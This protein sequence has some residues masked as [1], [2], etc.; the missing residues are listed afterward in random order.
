MIRTKT[1]DG[2]ITRTSFDTKARP[3]RTHVGTNDNG[4]TAGESSGTNDMTLVAE[5]VYD[6]ATNRVTS[7]RQ[8]YGTGGSDYRTTEYLYDAEGRR[9]VT[10]PPS[11][12]ISVVLYDHQGRTTAQG[13]YRTGASVTASTDPTSTATDRLA[14]TETSYDQRGQVWQTTRHEVN[15]SNGTL[16]S[17]LLA[18]HWFDAAGREIKTDGE[19]LTKSVYDRLGRMTR[20]FVLAKDNDRAT[21]YAD[22]VD[23][24][25]DIVL[26][27]RQTLYDATDGTATMS[28]SIERNY[29]DYR[30]GET[31]GALDTNADGNLGVVTAADIKGRVSITSMWYDDLDRLID[32]ASLGT[33]GGTTYTRSSYSSAPSRSATVLVS[34]TSYYDDG[35]VMSRTDPRGKVTLQT[36]DTAGRVTSTVR[37]FVNGAPSSATGDDDQIIRQVYANGLRTKYWVDLYPADTDGTPDSEDQVTTY[38]YGTSKGTS[39][40][41]SKIATGNLLQKVQYPDSSGG[42]DVVT[43]AYD[44]G[45]ALMWKKDQSGNVIE[46]DFD[47]AGRKQHERVTTLASGFDGQ[48]QRITT[49][50]D[51]QGRSSTVTS[52]SSPTVGAGTLVNEVKSTYDGWGNLTTFQVDPDSAIAGTGI[53]TKDLSYAYTTATTGR[54]TIRRTSVTLPGSTTV[55]YVYDATASGNYDS[56]AS[57]LSKMTISSVAVA[58]YRYMGF[59]NVVGVDYDEADVFQHRYGST[60]GSYP[61]LDQ[62]GRVIK[63]RWTKDLATDMDFVSVDVSYDENSNPLMTDDGI[64]STGFDVK[65]AIDGLD[66]VTDAEEGTLSGTTLSSQTRR[67][68]WSLTQT[69]NWTNEKLDL[70]GDGDWADAN[71]HNDT[72]THNAVNELTAR[73]T[74]TNGTNNYSLTYDA[75]GNLTDD[76]ETYAYEYDAWYRLRKIKDRGTSA[77]LS[78]HQYYGNGFRAGEHYDADQDSDVDG[79]DPWYW[80]AYDERWR[81][82]GTFVGSDSSP[83]ERFLHH[84]AG[85][86]GYGSSSYIDQVVLR[87]RDANTN[88]HASSDGTL[89]ER[90]YYCQNWRHDVVALVTAAGALKE[91]VRYSSYGVP[92]GIPLGDC[93]SDGDVDSADTAILLGAW[94]TSSPKC[95]LDLSGSIDAVDQTI[96]LS[97]NGS[98]AGRGS[99]S[100]C[101]SGFGLAGCCYDRATLSTVHVRRRVLIGEYGS[102]AQR[103]PLGNMDGSNVYL[104]ARASPLSSSDP[105]GEMAMLFF[106]RSAFFVRGCGDFVC[107]ADLWAA[108]GTTPLIATSVVAKITRKITATCCDGS[109]GATSITF[110]EYWGELPP[111]RPFTFTP[112]FDGPNTHSLGE[113]DRRLCAFSSEAEVLDVRLLPTGGVWSQDWANWVQPVTETTICLDANTDWMINPDSSPN[114]PPLWDQPLSTLRNHHKAT[115]SFGPTKNCCNGGAV[116]TQATCEP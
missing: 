25:G 105:T 34:T 41:D 102:W 30:T 1:P 44:T 18:L 7:T 66:R 54:N 80:F 61:D 26:E 99:L 109:Q 22:V 38:T 91:R 110:Y 74:D 65:Y 90:L 104:Y 21:I 97:Q 108:N 78:E 116:A 96:Q 5:T 72:R 75:A 40:G 37:N 27:E 29:S 95:D 51:D 113:E 46:T 69:G 11:S 43:Y 88:W 55:T 92:F 106:T 64:Y 28:V 16:G 68:Q 63:S 84:T 59:G 67:Q 9:V 3:Y 60:T 76:G 2:T 89:E 31:T 98:S 33:N 103:D 52:Y 17:S 53:P 107:G 6:D 39:A 114:P 86:N 10:K 82:V 111:L 87:E 23:V 4:E 57:R 85:G 58:R 112:F 48:V 79:T 49:A 47:S 24:A 14:L 77:V 12:P 8:F 13:L 115:S 45:R 81:I 94:G 32:T 15:Q 73:D 71:E 83:K 19:Q 62:F 56:E 50:Y 36:Y 20:S 93:D 70:N 35:T 42:T 101:Q 100:N